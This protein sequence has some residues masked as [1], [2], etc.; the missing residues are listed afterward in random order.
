MWH[1]QWVNRD[2]HRAC[3]I[4]VTAFL[5]PW[6]EVYQIWHENW[7]SLFYF[8]GHHVDHDAVIV[9]LWKDMR[10][11]L[12]CIISLLLLLWQSNSGF[13]VYKDLVALVSCIEQLKRRN[14][15]WVLGP[16]NV[17]C[18]FQSWVSVWGNYLHT[19]GSKFQICLKKF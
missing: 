13:N 6:K 4:L 8:W 7:A 3:M 14:S 18:V 12:C 9:W 1:A 15:I 19:K 11:D 10:L 16:R 2:S 5:F 17:F